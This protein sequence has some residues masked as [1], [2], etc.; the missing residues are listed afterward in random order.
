MPP[1]LSPFELLTLAAAHRL[2]DAAYGVTIRDDIGVLQGRDAAMASVYA[3][4]DR[5]EQLGLVKAWMSE[6]RAER[7][8]RARRHYSVTASGR[9]SIRRAHADAMRLWQAVPVPPA[10]KRR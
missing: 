3:A 10:G 5:L 9:E 7:G 8:G 1:I 2:G 6:P 4:L